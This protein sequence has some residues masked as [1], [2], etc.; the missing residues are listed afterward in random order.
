MEVPQNQ[1]ETVEISFLDAIAEMGVREVERPSV[2]DS[3]EVSA[4]KFSRGRRLVV[5]DVEVIAQDRDDMSVGGLFGTV[6]PAV[7]ARRAHPMY[8]A[9]MFPGAT[10]ERRT[11]GICVVCGEAGCGIGPFTGGNAR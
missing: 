6:A 3:L 7:E 10:P 8:Q 9:D 11:G 2:M 1:A 5:R 4:G